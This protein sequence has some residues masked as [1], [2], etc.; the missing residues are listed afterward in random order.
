MKKLLALFILLTLVVGMLS[1][2]GLLGG[3]N[4]TPPG[5]DDP[6]DNNTP[7]APD[8]GKTDVVI[9]STDA[10]DGPLVWSG[11]VD[12]VIV[13][14][15][16]S[17]DVKA[18]RQ[19]LYSLVGVAPD[20]VKPSTDKIEHEIVV[21]NLGR[22]ISNH[23]YAMLDRAVDLYSLEDKGESAFMLYAEG[24]SL[25]VVYSDMVARYAAMDYLQTYIK[26]TVFH[27]EGVIAL[28]EF[29]KVDFI[30]EKREA[31]R[32]EQ[33]AAIEGYL[34]KD[35]T[36]ALRNFY[37]LYDEDLYIYIANL[38]DPEIGGFYYSASGRDTNGFLP[39]LEST[40]QALGMLDTSG[41]TAGYRKE[42]I[43]DAYRAWQNMIPA[44]MA[45]QLLA[46]AKGLQDSDGY[47]YHPQW[48][49]VSTSR[50]GRDAGWAR[51]IIDSLHATPNYPYPSD[52]E[53]EGVSYN[54]GPSLVMPLGASVDDAV[55][56]AITT[57][58]PPT[59]TRVAE[60]LSSEEAW[61]KHLNEANVSTN[62]YSVFNN[63]SARTSEIKKAGLWDV[64]LT[65]L[66]EHQY[67]NGTWEPTV[68]YNSING[69]M[70]VSSFWTKNRPLPRAEAAVKSTLQVME[71]DNI[72]EI[73]G[74]T[75]VYNP[76][77]VLENILPYCGDAEEELRAQIVDNAALYINGTFEKLAVF[78]KNDGGFSYNQ[79]SSAAYSQE[80]YVAVEGS[81]ESDVNATSIAISTLVK[82]M[83]PVLLHG[84]EYEIPNV[85]GRYDTIYF[86]ETLD[87]LRGVIKKPYDGPEPEVETFDEFDPTEGGVSNGITLYPANSVSLNL[88]NETM[89]AD[90]YY[91]F[92]ASS[93][94]PNPLGSPTDLV[95]YM[96][97][98]VYDANNNGKIDDDGVE[99]INKNN[100]SNN[101][102]FDIVNSTIVGNC[103]V[104]ETDVMFEDYYGT[105]TPT[106]MQ[107]MFSNGANYN[108]NNSAWFNFTASRDADGN[109]YFLMA[110]NFAGADG[111]KET[112]LVG[113]IP[114]NKWVNLR[115]EMYKIYDG[116]GKLSVKVKI[117]VDGIYACESD[118]SNYETASESYFDYII[119]CVRFSCFRSSGSSMYINNSYAA[120]ITKNYV[121]EN[122]SDV[123]RDTEVKAPSS[124]DFETTVT[125][126]IYSETYSSQKIEEGKDRGTFKQT[127]VAYGVYG[128]PY[129]IGFSL[130][131]D[132]KDS[133]NW[134]LKVNSVN[135][136][137]AVQ[138][139]IDVDTEKE[140]GKRIHILEF[141]Y[142]FVN[143]S[144]ANQNIMQL[145][146]LDTNGIKMGGSITL[147]YNRTK[148]SDSG[149]VAPGAV[150]ISGNSAG[151]RLDSHTWYRLRV[152]IDSENKAIH[153][154][155]SN[156]NGA[157][158]FVA[159][160]PG[161]IGTGTTI[162]AL[163]LV[164]NAYNNTGVQYLD[165]ISY[166]V[167]DSVPTA[168]VIKNEMADA[169]H[170]TQKVVY[171][172]ETGFFPEGN[173]FKAT[174]NLK[175]DAESGAI[176]YV[177][178]TDAYNTALETLGKNGKA[179]LI[180]GIGT[181]FFI[182]D[183]PAVT[184]G[185]VL[186]AVTR[187]GTQAPASI[188]VIASKLSDN[189]SVLEIT[190]D[191]YMDYNNFIAKDLPTM[192]L[193]LW[194]GQ[195]EPDDVA[196]ERRLS[197]FA[198][199]STTYSENFFFNEYAPEGKETE[200]MENAFKIGSY[201]L[202]SHTW[203]TI[204]VIITGG[205]QYTYI[206]ERGGD[207]E[208]TATAN[209][210]AELETLKYA[211]IYIGS[212]NNNG[213]QYYDNIS[214]VMNDSYDDPT[215]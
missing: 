38:Y 85:Y 197:F 76:W 91:K 184:G 32:E 101:A 22:S 81:E 125:E 190:F 145:D 29:N 211:R 131:S 95:Y 96:K 13:S 39:D 146:L 212:Y 127:E 170:P 119:N 116:D 73:T 200:K 3:G 5:S 169:T 90:G 115:F 24:G 25:A 112:N 79:D 198:Y 141:D 98:K 164:F 14:E 172:F 4:N 123:D 9:E 167:S 36:D 185:K 10:S 133:A 192:R 7:I 124:Y 126:G 84:T 165:N 43:K 55:L 155:Y 121:P 188:D 31:A 157:S 92:F 138:G 53:A 150:R 215:K 201:F 181:A 120:K 135:A 41:L 204:K 60:E 40:G 52:S 149:K 162:G 177:A 72:E 82:Y 113:A 205:K 173:N 51:T 134:V 70:K 108:P 88:N 202:D 107:L 160:T 114:A 178:G 26:A 203:Y 20:V 47:F 34:G 63:L 152:V 214:Y 208:L 196:A 136:S 27:A 154:H 6:G 28:K 64:T 156:D 16:E 23:A 147:I 187:N 33:F 66:E 45:E 175:A 210:S 129:G 8:N 148:A 206:A 46:F 166:S 67:E 191:Y 42:Y 99:C 30:A 59:V 62:S 128:Y 56:C 171:D 139:R 207:F 137:S 19:Y 111:V 44:D 57:I 118:S 151:Q 110:D 102:Q 140:E 142:Y 35:N 189:V 80:A 97:S 117:F 163:R 132:P 199:P 183:D 77:V 103:F 71:L 18:V 176:T 49:T 195:Y 93:V 161:E 68:C 1:S 69:L 12:Y 168:E 143:N 180:N 11:D 74:I 17:E 194:D 54:G 144:A 37:N 15:E 100:G 86:L 65:W 87:E 109:P 130:D 89:D 158:W 209:Y 94:V 2:C 104:F 48:A 193:M 50:R 186:Q 174:T 213:R 179:T 58:A 153:Y 83:M 105:G 78:M 122:V 75:F 21:G 159:A 182:V 106:T 61:I